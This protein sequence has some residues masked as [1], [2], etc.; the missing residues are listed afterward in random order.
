MLGKTQS[1]KGSSYLENENS[2]QMAF[3]CFFR[4]EGGRASFIRQQETKLNVF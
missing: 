2:L 4:K 1:V 3:R